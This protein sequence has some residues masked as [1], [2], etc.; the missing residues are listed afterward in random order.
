MNRRAIGVRKMR[1][2]PCGV[3]C[4]SSSTAHFIAL[5]DGSSN[6][7]AFHTDILVY[8]ISFK[9]QLLHLITA[10]SYMRLYSKQENLRDILRCRQVCGPW[11]E[12]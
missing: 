12:I 8:L 2:D 3:I 1:F 5:L 4:I 10:L 9:P 7:F 6:P 11:D